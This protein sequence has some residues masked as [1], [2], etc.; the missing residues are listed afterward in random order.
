PDENFAREVMQ[1]FSIGL[2]QLNPDGSVKKGAD[3]QPSETYTGADISGLAKVFTGFSYGGP[4][5]DNN[6][7]YGW[8]NELNDPNRFWMPMQGYSQYHSISEKKFLGQTVAAGAKADPNADLKVALDTLYNHPNIGPF[9]GKQLIQ[10]LVTSNPS[11]A[12]VGRVAKAFESGGAGRGDMRA[13]VKAVLLDAEARDPAIAA[14][15][16]FGKVREPVLR[17]TAVLRAFDATSDSGKFLVGTTDDPGTQLGQS[18][19]RAPSVFNFYRPGYVAPGTLTGDAGL[20][21]PELQITNE[22]TVAGYANYMRGVLESGAG[23]R[24]VDYKAARNDVQLALAAELALA[25]TPLDLAERV[26]SRLMGDGANAELKAVIAQAV[27][28][29]VVPALNAKGDNQK[30]I[31][32]ARRNRAALAVYLAAVAPE[33]IVQR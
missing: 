16:G 24:G 20:L 32:T 21:A 17:L 9:I 19:M 13:V 5:T 22:S 12:Y 31:D 2:Y 8:S 30:A 14:D 3:G 4:D 11:P 7:F 33:F 29:V 10:R 6:R 25:D 27:G 23:Q 1:L 15:P 26:T 28:T 18:P